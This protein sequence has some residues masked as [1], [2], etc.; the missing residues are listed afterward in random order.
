MINIV[1]SGCCGRMGKRICELSLKD[2][3]LRLIAGVEKKGHPQIGKKILPDCEAIVWDDIVACSQDA[4]VIIEFSTPQATLEHLEKL[5]GKKISFVIGTTG[6]SQEE[7]DK[8]REISSQIPILISPNMSFGVNVLFETVKFLA[9]LLGK[10][11]E[12][13]VIELH[14]HNKVDAPSG[15]A[16][17][18]I[19][20]IEEAYGEK[21]K[22]I[23]GREGKIGP[24]A[25]EEI[26]VHA[27]RLG[28]IVGE[29]QV[30]FAGNGE[31]IELIHRAHS[32]DIF[33]LGALKAAKYIIKKKSGIYSML[34]LLQNK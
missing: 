13:E 29:H 20:F 24:R 3:T 21:L 34:D 27:L 26:G 5:L 10:D 1:V 12:V 31:R 11:Y 25:K 22:Y 18:I 17:K 30:I 14:H 32:R 16:K 19:S 7:L 33:A 15:T 6:F 2:D 4:D 8:I 23:Y 28:D 9:K